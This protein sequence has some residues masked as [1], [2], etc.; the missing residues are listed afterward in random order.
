MEQW[1]LGG[2]EGNEKIVQDVHD[3]SDVE[4]VADY[5]FQGIR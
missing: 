2:G 3:S 5:P 1:D 4:F